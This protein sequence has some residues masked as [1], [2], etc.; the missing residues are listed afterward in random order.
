MIEDIKE[1]FDNE[2]DI[3]MILESISFLD[4]ESIIQI[5]QS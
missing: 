2:E 4:S 3:F 5:Y 1:I